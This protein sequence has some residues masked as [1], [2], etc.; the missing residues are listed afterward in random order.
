MYGYL[1]FVC[2]PSEALGWLIYVWVLS[3]AARI[4]SSMLGRQVH[5]GVEGNKELLACREVL[6]MMI[7]RT[8]SQPPHPSGEISST[9]IPLDATRS[10]ATSGAERT[11]TA[12]LALLGSLLLLGLLLLLL[13]LLLLGPLGGRHLL[14]HGLL[15]HGVLRGWLHNSS[16][17]VTW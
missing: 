2:C 9:S 5:G 17:W 3:T 7:N 16:A 10:T 13:G 11:E 8:K 6:T 15:L 14:L 4:S 12:C 1:Q